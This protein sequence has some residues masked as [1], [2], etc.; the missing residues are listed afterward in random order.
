MAKRNTSKFFSNKQEKEVA[1]DIG[2]R[3]VIASGSLW[4][5]KGDARSD[6]YL[7]ECKTTGKEKYRLHIG[8]WEKIS[9]EALKDGLR[10][11]LMCIELG[12]NHKKAVFES[13]LLHGDTMFEYYYSRLFAQDCGDKLSFLVT[14][15]DEIFQINS[16]LVPF[17]KFELCIMD[18]SDFLDIEGNL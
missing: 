17:K 15:K 11:P 13:T 6:K 9:D 12:N 3:V 5:M 2:G 10:S 1:K 18:W 16:L 4:G 14:K 7:C 8:I